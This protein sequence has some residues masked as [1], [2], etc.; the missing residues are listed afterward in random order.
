MDTEKRKA[1]IEE[2]KRK[3][4]VG[5]VYCVECT[6]NGQKW[7]KMT[8]DLA[9]MKNRFEFSV[10]INSCLE[11]AML[12]AWNEFGKESFTFSIL[13]MLKKKEDQTDKEYVDDLK[14]LLDMCKSNV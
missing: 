6:G 7:I 1:M 8:R 14:V 13:E 11:P 9:S 2:Y 12:E 5:G 3:V 4:E 10:A